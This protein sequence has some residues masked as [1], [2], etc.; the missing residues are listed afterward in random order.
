MKTIQIIKLNIFGRVQGITFRRTIL[1][2]TKI[3]NIK[4]TIK[5]LENGSVEIIIEKNI[6]NLNKIIGFL[7]KNPGFSIINQ[8][9]K[10]ELEKNTN[11]KNFEEFQGFKIIKSK[12]YLIDKIESLIHLANY[13]FKFNI[14]KNHLK[15]TPKHIVIIPDG[16]RRWA[17]KLGLKGSEGHKKAITKNRLLSFL[18]E[19]KNIGV[20]EISV[21]GFS[22]ENWSRSEEELNSLFDI[23][24]KSI[25]QI[26]NY[27]IKKK[28]KFE[29][30]G[31][32]TKL[33]EDIIKSMNELEENTKDFNDFKVNLLLDYGG[34]EEII[35]SINKIIKESNLQKNKITEKEFKNVLYTKN[36]I[37]PDM[38]IRTSNEKRLSG[39][40]PFQAT[41]AELFFIK[42]H[43]PEFTT[44]DFKKLIYQFQF[45]K[46]IL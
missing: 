25:K 10:E 33:P 11:N 29:H 45:R 20:K 24:R 16:N 23:F 4:G 22:T 5:N 26:G 7:K 30:I 21:W 43:F 8:I 14:N 12:S 44:K 38:I 39:L 31:R 34:R 6:T 32:K 13:Q 37:D 27:C 42:K 9:E 36:C 46:R 1:N 28:V 41:Y 35:S 3:N 40:Y 18:N 17:R 2:F 19:T 15:I